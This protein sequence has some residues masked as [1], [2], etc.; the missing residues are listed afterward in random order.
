LQ[1]TS[2]NVELGNPHYWVPPV[3]LSTARQSITG[4]NE[5]DISSCAHGIV[6][7]VHNECKDIFLQDQFPSKTICFA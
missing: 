5:G 1:K 2:K 4:G 3:A 7:I 6:V